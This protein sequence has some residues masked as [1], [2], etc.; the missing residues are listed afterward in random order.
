MDK[1]IRNRHKADIPKNGSWGGKGSQIPLHDNCRSTLKDQIARPHTNKLKQLSRPS[2]H[3]RGFQ[4]SPGL[5]ILKVHK[6]STCACCFY[7]RIAMEDSK[8]P[9]PF[10]EL[11][12]R[13]RLR[14]KEKWRDWWT[15]GNHKP[16]VTVLNIPSVINVAFTVCHWLTMLA[17][18]KRLETAPTPISSFP[19]FSTPRLFRGVGSFHWTCSRVYVDNL[20]ILRIH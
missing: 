15:P 4:L 11:G 1:T 16:I 19:T 8:P 5:R 20:W 2:T 17:M 12:L 3:W 10:Q 7:V 14:R 9:L 13:R 18:W 6:L